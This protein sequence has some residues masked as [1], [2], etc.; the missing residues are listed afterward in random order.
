VWIDLIGSYDASPPK[1]SHLL[2]VIHLII[3]VKEQASHV[4]PSAAETA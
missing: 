4:V 3:P 1:T 2:Y